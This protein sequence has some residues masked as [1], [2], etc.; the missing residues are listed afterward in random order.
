[1]NALGWG[2]AF[3]SSV[4]VFIAVLMVPVILARIRAEKALLGDAFGTEYEAYRART[5]RLVPGVYW[6]A[7]S[8]AVVAA[9][10][11]C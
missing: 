9:T 6:V 2:L 7:C 4:G 5:S 8:T 1:M 3:R 11:P 10:R